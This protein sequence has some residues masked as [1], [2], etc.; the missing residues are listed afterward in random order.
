[1]GTQGHPWLFGLSRTRTCAVGR[2]C[3]GGGASLEGHAGP[4]SNS[5][6]G[7]RC[8]H[9][10][11]HLAPLWSLGGGRAGPVRQLRNGLH[12]QLQD[13][14]APLVPRRG[15]PLPGGV[16]PPGSGTAGWGGRC[17]RR[18]RGEEDE[19]EG[20]ETKAGSDSGPPGLMRQRAGSCRGAAR[21]PPEGGGEGGGAPGVPRLL[22]PRR[23]GRT[24]GAARS[25]RPSLPPAPGSPG[26]AEPRGGET[27]RRPAGPG[28]RERGRA[29]GR[30]TGD[31]P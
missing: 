21:A 16:Q 13:R 31:S 27:R 1:M 15:S 22:P 28:H 9:R 12:P 5:H 10:C 23:S 7:W 29:R 17:R 14:G 4:H 2:C 25:L 8:H 19:E 6:S 3:V 20:G 26:P 18:H 30:G 11:Q 24:R